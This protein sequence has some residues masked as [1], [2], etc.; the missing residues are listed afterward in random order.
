MRQRERLE[1]SRDAKNFLIHRG[2]DGRMSD[3]HFITRPLSIC[4][5]LVRAMAA[6]AVLL[7]H[8]VQ[9]GIYTGPWPFSQMFQHDAVI[10]F[11]VLSGMVIASSVDRPG[12]NMRAY[13]IARAARILPVTLPALLF[14]AA[15]YI[16]CQVL[17][18]QV[19]NPEF[20]STLTFRGTVLPALFL[21]E[22]VFG[23]GPVWNAPYWS[24]CYE[25]W[26]YLLFGAAI[27]LRG[28]RRL[29][30]LL[31]MALLAGPKILML[32]P[33]WLVGVWLA[34]RGSTFRLSVLPGLI[35]I[36]LCVAAFS[37]MNEGI[38]ATTQRFFAKTPFAGVDLDHAKF[39][40][41]DLLLGIAVA[42]GFIG[43]RPVAGAI[44]TPLER[45]ARPISVLAGS[46]FTL[47]LFH[48]PL[49]CLLQGFGLT[50]GSSTAGFS[51]L[52]AG[53]I[54]LSIG[55]ARY[56]EQRRE[57]VRG[58]LEQWTTRSHNKL[59]SIHTSPA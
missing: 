53:V 12:A 19:E 29:I 49:L 46:S 52:M 45:T 43:L 15:A 40:F 38:W 42:A 41:N 34:R 17:G 25:V 10:V 56:T 48:W 14:G 51:G 2:Y 58:W 1:I 32:L 24:L 31:V 59:S 28:S 36:V 8:A 4:L 27:F 30:V 9:L 18:I 57:T 7:G 35:L 11:F 33:V 16:V 22:S 47:Y 39:A 23:T 6:V 37:L 26:Y 13:L 5:D 44:A 55:I 3:R 54:A 20:N 50:A 21:S